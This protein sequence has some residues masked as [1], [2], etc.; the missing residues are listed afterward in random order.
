[1]NKNSDYFVWKDT[2]ER[3]TRRCDNTVDKKRVNSC[4]LKYLFG[5]S[6]V[7]KKSPK[8]PGNALSNVLL[9]GFENLTADAAKQKKTPSARFLETT[10]RVILIRELIRINSGPN[11]FFH[12]FKAASIGWINVSLSV[13]PDVGW[14]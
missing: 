8:T 3:V 6:A 14:D 12:W 11:I 5:G 9:S 2:S 7:T 4:V 10:L 1:M 13:G